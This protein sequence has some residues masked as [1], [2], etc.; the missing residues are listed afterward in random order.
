M[1]YDTTLSFQGDEFWSF[2][3]LLQGD[4]QQIHTKWVTNYNT[5]CI[6][7]LAFVINGEK[8]WAHLRPY[9]QPKDGKFAHVVHVILSSWDLDAQQGLFKLTMKSNA[10]QAMAEI[11][12]LASNKVTLPSSIPSLECGE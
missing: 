11:V 1:Y 2:H 8:K 5:K 3:E 10:T 6:E 12:A 4:H 7:H 9:G